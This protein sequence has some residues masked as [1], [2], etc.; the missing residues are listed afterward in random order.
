MAPGQEPPERHLERQLALLQE[1]AERL[2]A[3]IGEIEA[4]RQE[5]HT[6]YLQDRSP[7]RRRP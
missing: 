2:T 5:T 4:R 7:D 3:G 1:E 6:R